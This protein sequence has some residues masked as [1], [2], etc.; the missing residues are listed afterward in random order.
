MRGSAR[1]SIE[2]GTMVLEL[3]K[4]GHQQLLATVQKRDR[5]L[6]LNLVAQAVLLALSLGI[7]VW[8]TTP[9]STSNPKVLIFAVP[10]AFVFALLY[11]VEDGAVTSLSMYLSRLFGS[12]TQR[13]LSFE[14]SPELRAFVPFICVRMFAQVLAF[15]VIPALLVIVGRIKLLPSAWFHYMGIFLIFCV[16]AYGGGRKFLS[17]RNQTKTISK[18]G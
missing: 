1:S 6:Y 13:N 14:A 9:P 18:L 3:Y 8:S 12:A 5:V 11:V 16:L 15:C 7:S 17:L 4:L 2:C 10:I